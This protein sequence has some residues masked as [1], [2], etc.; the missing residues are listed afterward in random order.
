MRADDPC[1]RYLMAPPEKQHSRVAGQ[2]VRG[3]EGR[4]AVG[5]EVEEERV[6]VGVGE[7]V[8]ER[9]QVGV[10]G[11]QRA[12]GLGDDERVVGEGEERVQGVERGE[13]VVD[14]A[15]EEVGGGGRG[16]SQFTKKKQSHSLNSIYTSILKT[17][18]LIK[19]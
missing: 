4:Q 7:G 19:R 14:D 15:G 2:V 16:G 11:G 3:G 17:I 9:A 1:L 13:V 5:V 8:V 6:G 12:A 10:G 18:H